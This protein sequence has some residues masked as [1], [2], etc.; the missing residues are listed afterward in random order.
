MILNQ[1]DF[2]Q[3]SR[4]FVSDMEPEFIVG[5]SEKLVK[6]CWVR[7]GG[8]GWSGRQGGRKTSHEVEESKGRYAQRVDRHGAYKVKQRVSVFVP[9]T[10]VLQATCGRGWCPL[11]KG[12][13]CPNLIQ[14][15][16][17]R[18]QEV[19]DM[20]R[21][22]SA[23]RPMLS[24]RGPVADDFLL[25]HYTWLSFVAY[26]TWNPTEKESWEAQIQCG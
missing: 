15:K 25:P 23:W 7:S 26:L 5:N 6:A 3:K 14:D 16:G 19:R 18:G 8:S 10:S 11:S 12:Y 21:F 2:Y 24:C 13:T 4:T 9:L 20:C 1:S 22:H 17:T